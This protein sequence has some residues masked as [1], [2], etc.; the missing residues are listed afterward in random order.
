MDGEIHALP[1]NG[2]LFRVP[3]PRDT[4]AGK[5]G[6]LYIDDMYVFPGDSS[7]VFIMNINSSVTGEHPSLLPTQR[8]LTV[9]DPLDAAEVEELTY[10]VAFSNPDPE[11][12]QSFQLF[13]LAGAEA[14]DNGAT[15]ELVLE[16]RSG[17]TVSGD[18]VGEE[19]L[20]GRVGDSFYIDLSLLDIVNGA[21][22]KGT[23]LDLSGGTPRMRRTASP[24]IRS[25]RS[26]S[27]CPRHPRLRLRQRS[28]CCVV[29]HQGPD[30]PNHWRLDPTGSDTH[31]VADLL[32]RRRPVQPPRQHPTA[33][34]GLRGR[35]QEYRRTRSLDHPPQRSAKDPEGYGSAVL[36]SELFPDVMSYVDGS[37][38]CT[39]R[40][41][42]MVGPFANHVAEAMLSLRHEHRRSVGAHVFGFRLSSATGTSPTWCQPPNPGGSRWSNFRLGVRSLRTSGFAPTVTGRVRHGTRS[43][44]APG[45]TPEV[46][47]DGG[48]IE[49]EG[50]AQT[51]DDVAQVAAT[52]PPGVTDS[53]GPGGRERQDGELFETAET[54]QPVVASGP[55]QP[56]VARHERGG[57]TSSGQLD[58]T[59]LL[60]ITHPRAAPT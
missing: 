21:V 1:R 53:G 17:E 26:C 38:R 14:S 8:P 46:V 42:E 35:W 3:P 24:I 50:L 59:I 39:A 33:G 43:G 56:G 36:S 19:I 51:G 44:V 28:D 13:S 15:G 18:D 47:H 11:G 7:T 60:R 27:R 32:S 29:H 34:R 30:E 58:T 20:A 31:D 41:S 49:F 40:G 9:Q 6:Q 37:L 48:V 23:A 55:R 5:T 10:R 2:G 16:G 22:R 45:R 52:A 57:S 12:R 54:E 4:L 25:I